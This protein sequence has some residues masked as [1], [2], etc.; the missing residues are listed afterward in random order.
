MIAEGVCQGVRY[1]LA[2]TDSGYSCHLFDKQLVINES[3]KD[4]LLQRVE[5]ENYSRPFANHLYNR[6][7]K[8]HRLPEDVLKLIVAYLGFTD[9]V[10]IAKVDSMLRRIVIE[11][12]S[13]EVTESCRDISRF[14]GNIKVLLRPEPKRS[15]KKL[16]NYILPTLVVKPSI[17]LDAYEPDIKYFIAK[18]KSS[19]GEAAFSGILKDLKELLEDLYA[20][21]RKETVVENVKRYHNVIHNPDNNKGSSEDS[22]CIGIPIVRQIPISYRLAT[23]PRE[24]LDWYIKKRFSAIRF[25][26]NT[27]TRLPSLFWTMD[28]LQRLDLSH[29][30]FEFLPKEIGN[31][32]LLTHLTLSYN[33]L[34]KLP[35]EIEELN[36]LEVLVVD[37]N[38]LD[39]LPL[40]LMKC[41][42]LRFINAENNPF[43]TRY[44][45]DLNEIRNHC[46]QNNIILDVN[47][48]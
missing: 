34:K 3:S 14:Y 23:L 46:R 15:V 37:H 19:R 48:F 16:L 24:S 30:L 27:L 33:K 18:L 21:G 44:M 12:R 41:G 6:M 32:K 5:S 35:D 47:G 8:I 42:A 39:T 45:K 40:T 22:L 43:S 10:T 2:E 1:K 25:N 29:N 13:L 38:E 11:L 7:T 28:F 20:D 26:D 36:S 4:A 31:L 17:G 9:L